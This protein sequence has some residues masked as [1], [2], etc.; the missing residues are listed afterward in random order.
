MS[1]SKYYSTKEIFLI[2]VWNFTY[3]FLFRYSP[4]LLYGWRNLILRIFGAKIGKKV[5]IYP[6]AK[7]S[8]PWLI[9]IGAGSFISWNVRVYNLGEIKI[10]EKTII[11]QNVHLCGG[12][13]DFRNPGFKLLRT[14]LTIGSH[15]WIAADAFI[16]P[17][18]HVGDNAVVAARAVVVKD[19][20]QGAVVGGNPANIISQ[21]VLDT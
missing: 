2:M 14:G 3:I 10:G 20:P 11:S 21:R 17:S 16:G 18:I 12:T 19:V 9:E 13:H 4:R 7:F 1:I 5:K 15:V 6:S 8:I